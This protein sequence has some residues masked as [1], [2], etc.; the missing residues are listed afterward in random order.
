MT[1]KQILI[2]D[3]CKLTLAIARDIL[4]TAGYAVIVAESGIE[5][6]KYIYGG[7]PPAVILI[8]VEMPLL[9]GD[10]KVRLLKAAPT[11]R[12]IPVILMSHKSESELQALCEASGAD[13]YIPKPLPKDA[14]LALVRSFS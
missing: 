10:R 6:N 7:S 12:D 8:D 1:E 13:S 11:S 4:E 9:R 14:L 2:I 5:A 3:D